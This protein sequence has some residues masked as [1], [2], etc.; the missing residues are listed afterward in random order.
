MSPVSVSITG[1]VNCHQSAVRESAFQSTHLRE[2][3][4]VGVIVD[5]KR[6]QA[7]LFYRQYGFEPIP[8]DLLKLFAP[9]KDMAGP[10]AQA[11][12]FYAVL[13]PHA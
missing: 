4:I 10:V 8:D 12:A 2:I 7:Q 3:G 13:D 11:V 9:I 5:A 1:Q 6:E